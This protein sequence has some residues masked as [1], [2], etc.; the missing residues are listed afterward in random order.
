MP[1][2]RQLALVLVAIVASMGASKR[3]PN[4]IVEAPTPPIAEQVG[5]W[6]EYWRK[7]KAREWLG[8][9]MPPWS[10]P[11]PLYV[12][13]TGAG[14]GGATSFNFTN[15]Q[16][17]Q[18]MNVE[19]SLERI[20]QSVLP[21]EVTHTVFAYYFRC[22]VPRWA[23]E[24]GAVL[25]EDDLERG[26]H[27][28]MVRQILNAGRAIPLNRLF[29]LHD[30]PRDMRDVGSLYAEGFSV[31]NYLVASSDRPTFLRFLGHGMQY[32]WD[33][34][35]QN[36]YHYQNVEQLQA[37][38]IRY[39]QENRNTSAPTLLAHN[40]ATPAP[41]DPA[42]RVIVRLTAPPVQPLQDGPAP[43][44]RGQAPEEERP[45]GWADVPNRLTAGSPGYLP[46]Y[47]PGARP[48]PQN[49]W[50]SPTPL[51]P[52]TWQPGVRLGDPQLDN[53]AAPSAPRR[54]SSA[55]PVGYPY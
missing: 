17:S 48:A 46:N 12:K 10:E 55:S 9:E 36:Y 37:A 31:S 1:T 19:G 8:R 44:V 5:Q 54:P 15:G 28:M 11:C 53:Q 33:S 49:Q 34:A 38:W 40:T 45:A 25:S 13:V 16:V 39:L 2:R 18:V 51:P 52:N 50:Q 22:P 23:D 20:L 6:A 29:T 47:D 4:F 41:T 43:T 27:D 30:Y 21:H 26:R 14:A 32:G 42:H 3:T 7:E 24:G 35:L